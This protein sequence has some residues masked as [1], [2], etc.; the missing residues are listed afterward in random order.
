[1]ESVVRNARDAILVTEAWPIDDPGPK[2]VYANESFTR[3][4]GYSLEEVVGQTPRILQ[5]PDTDR[6]R[7][8][9]VRAALESLEPVRV[10]LLNYRKDGTQFWVELDISPIAEDEGEHTHWLAVQRDVTERRKQEAALKESEEQ[11][12]SIQVQYASD[13]ITIL[14]RDGT[15]RYQSPAIAALGYLPEEV[16]GQNLYDYIHP[17]DLGRIT[18]EFTRLVENPGASHSMEVRV[19]TADG[20]W[21]CMEGIG[22]NLLNDPRVGGIVINSRDITG[23]KRAE[24]QLRDAE[25]RYRTLVEQIPGA[26]YIAKSVP[27]RAASYRVSYMSP[28][29]EEILGY[30]AQRFTEDQ[31]FWNEIIH[32]DDL[33]RVVKEDRRTDETGDPFSVEYRMVCRD[34]RIVWIREEALLIRDSEGEAPY[35]QGVMTDVTERRRAQD[36]LRESEERYRSVAESVREVVFQTDAEG[37]YVFLNPAWQDVTGFTVEESLGKS[38]LEFIHP[39]DLQRDLEDFERLGGRGDDYTEY[40]A[41]FRARDGSLHDVEIKFRQHFDEGGNLAGSSGTINDI[42]ERKKTERELQES[43]RRFRQLFEQSVDAM[44]VHDEEGRFVD[45]NSQA[46]NLLGY[47]R[48]ELL[49][50]SVAD[51]SLNVLSPEE[52]TRKEK[53]GSTLW[54]R[55]TA[56]EPGVFSRGHEEENVRKDGTVFPVEV[57]VGSVDYGG[58]RMVLASVRDITERRRTEEAL[59]ESEERFRS[60]FEDASVGMALVS[61]EDRPF[62]VNR[63]LCEMLGYP[64]EEI[65][66]KRSSEFTHPDDLEVTDDRSDRLIAHDGPDNMSVEKRYVCADGRVVWA[67]SDVSVVRDSEGEPSHFIC[68]F[69]DITKRKQAEEALRQSEESFRGAFENA[70]TGVALVDLDN[71]YI[72]VNHALC[73]MLGYPKEELVGKRSFDLTHPEDQMKSRG[74]QRWML[75][76]NSPDTMRLEKRYLRKDGGVVWAISDVSLVRDSEG[77]P[78][79]LVSHFQDITERKNLEEQLS[80]QAF[81]DPLTGLPNRSSLQK[82]F[83]QFTGYPASRPDVRQDEASYVGLLFLDLDGFKEIND[84]MGHDTGDKLLQAVAERLRGSLRTGDVAARF[85]G[86]EFCILLNKVSGEDEA[87]R[88]AGRLKDNLEAPFSLGSSSVSLTVSIG[89]AVEELVDESRSLDEL[90]R[91]ADAAMYRAKKRGGAFYEIVKLG[92]N[93]G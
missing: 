5:G 32:P 18:E 92:E 24:E 71:R 86:D 64:E 19:R 30:P 2:I 73:E 10:E 70:S 48:E 65:L 40:E 58:R 26:I 14:E 78:S 93:T 9:E 42:T 56:G 83:E 59:R 53:E 20:A 13:M 11:L 77:N 34:G 82:D 62:R 88:A 6:S 45:C 55:A 81:H 68:Q 52:R 23:R 27:G 75:D 74:R 31:D 21:R 12:R 61:L 4:T 17:E 44:Y 72:R 89:I 49:S 46:C 33:D 50:R 69:Q 51:I 63:A 16:V 8:D 84:S 38:Y 91:E 67:I 41:R 15:V 80:Y 36:D 1:M 54:Q 79:H 90:L 3:M 28:R 29:V 43:E 57:R 39:D 87:I 76:E 25:K 7:L 22:N 66:G 60:S 47:T 37:N 35:W 85:G